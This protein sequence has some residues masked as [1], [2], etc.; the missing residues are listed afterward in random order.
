MPLNKN[1]L[2]RFRIIDACLT[3][4]Q[5]PYPTMEQVIEKIEAQLGQSI[6]DSLFTKD[7]QQM[8]TIYGAPI[9]YNR[10]HK[11]YYYDQEGFSIREFP[12]THEEIEALDYSTAL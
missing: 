1:A 5:R 9:K 7:L 12:L 8:K 4:R 10:F 3:N 2:L 6:S 11:G